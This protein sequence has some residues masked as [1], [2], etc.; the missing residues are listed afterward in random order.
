MSV[1]IYRNKKGQP[2]SANFVVGEVVLAYPSLFEKSAPPGSNNA[3]KF[4]S[5]LVFSADQYANEIQPVLNAL[6]AEA[7]QNGETDKP[8]FR[9]GFTACAD[10]DIYIPEKTQ[11]MMTCNAKSDNV[12]EVV[13][14]DSRTPVLDP[15]KLRDGARC[16]VEMNFYTYNQMSNIGIGVGIS[17]VLYMSAGE[18]LNTGGGRKS[19]ADSFAG[20]AVNTNVGSGAPAP[21]SA[22]AP[23]GAPAPQPQPQ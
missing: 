18:A 5:A 15:G 11:G 6:A 7:F 3:P 1:E 20:V 19:A 8:G 16:Y 14:G 13:E 22:P 9:W 2:V 4:N 17:K 21:S 12:I 10:K 23:S